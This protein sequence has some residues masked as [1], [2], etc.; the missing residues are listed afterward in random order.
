MLGLIV[1]QVSSGRHPWVSYTCTR[2]ATGS[3]ILVGSSVQASHVSAY[4][5]PGTGTGRDPTG[6]WLV[7]G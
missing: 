5:G 6:T 2:T 1:L 3:G 4:P 7:V